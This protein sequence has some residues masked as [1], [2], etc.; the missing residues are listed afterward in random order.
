MNK[1]EIFHSIPEGFLD[2]PPDRLKSVL[3]APALLH[4]IGEKEPPLFLVTL[5]H[6]NEPTGVGAIQK[7]LKKYFVNGKLEGL[8]RSLILFVGN[9][10]SAKENLRR[11]P[12][13]N[14][15]NRIWNGGDSPEHE[16]ARS[17]IEYAKSQN[18]FFCVDIHNTSG[19][20]PH[21]SCVNRLDA[22]TIN[23]AR[24]FST[25]LIY[26]TEPHEVLS[27]AFSNICPA[28][29]IEAGM[30]D[31]PISEPH[32]LSFLEKVFSLNSLPS[33]LNEADV[34]VYHSMVRIKVPK[35][36]SIVFGGPS[37]N[38][39]YC[40]LEALDSLNFNLLPVGT[41]LGWRYNPDF[42]LIILD[43]NNRDVEKDYIEYCGNEIRLKRSVI[44]AMLTTDKKIVH[45]DCL[46]YLM[47]PYPLPENLSAKQC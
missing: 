27:L 5:L 45:Q 14:D 24:I 41:L 23:L 47:E 8:P 34:K 39:D 28:I 32:V 9:V 31:D 3:K 36:C 1:P 10:Q 12:G 25:T 20:N 40:F 22:Q 21:Y 18:V 37:Q 6:G 38:A 19:K 13:Q 46:G 44:P 30:P 43:E 7:F 42:S 4:L 17:V 26:F 35:E 15:F 2:T 29:T 11:L 33:T 16:M